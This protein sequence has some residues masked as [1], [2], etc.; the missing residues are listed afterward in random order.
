MND[1]PV[2]K[3]WVDGHSDALSEPSQTFMPTNLGRADFLRAVFHE[4]DDQG[5]CYCVL[6]TWE[7]LPEDLPSDL[8]IAV[9]PRHRDKLPGV[10]GALSGQGFLPV[11]CLNYAVN[12][13]YFVFCWFHG[14][15]LQ[16]VA[17]DVIFEHRRGG[18]ILTPG[19]ILVAGRR[20][21]D[22][23]WIPNPVVELNYLLTKKALKGMV[24]PHTE[25][26]LKN[27]IEEVGRPRA[28]EVAC[29]LYG[30]KWKKRVVDACLD[31]TL[32]SILS[33]LGE[34]VR[35]TAILRCPFGPIRNF[36]SDSTRR[37]KRWLQPTGIFV[38]ILGP[39]GVGKSTLA[40]QLVERLGP[41]F[42]RHRVFHFRPMLIKPQKETGH[43]VTDPHSY[44]IRGKL[45]SA[46]RLIGFFA[47]FCVGYWFVM[48][49]LLARS[50]L[51]IFDRYFY[52]IT[53]DTV[54][55]RYG[56]PLWLPRILAHLIPPSE[57]L[58][59]VMDAEVDVILSRKREIVPEELKR[60]RSSYINLTLEGSQAALIK[61][62]EGIEKSSV[63]ASRAIAL[64]L[65]E[66]FERRHGYWLARD[67]PMAHECK[68]AEAT[69]A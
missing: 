53:I 27:L 11:Q 20:R 62:D 38:V 12:A 37:I 26:Q 31:G 56:G 29:L 6:H 44:A 60:L 61:T 25:K 7:G 50:G 8:D 42:R 54:R 51:V 10:F 22:S 33:R 17:L 5:V 32:P 13:Y 34:P 23:F 18:M 3:T 39:D 16:H 36:F 66:R 49:Q 58:C 64:Y 55:Y 41:A 43:P 69:Q 21:H 15:E 65:A 2:S 46:A 4:L 67:N 68:P 63:A 45:M 57:L 40:A 59:L 30:E 47:D 48:R 52:D 1:H 9:H 14:L 19:E 24:L 28:E 35:L